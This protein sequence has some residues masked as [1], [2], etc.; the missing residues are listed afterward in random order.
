M[1]TNYF[2]GSI[3]IRQCDGY[4]ENLEFNS[5]ESKG[6]TFRYPYGDATP[7]E[8]EAIS[9]FVK[10]VTNAYNKLTVQIDGV[11]R[12]LHLEQYA[13]QQSTEVSSSEST[14]VSA[15]SQS[16]ALGGGEVSTGIKDAPFEED[17]AV[18]K[19]VQRALEEAETGSDKA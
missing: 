2:Y 9:Q 14:D 12:D 13:P 4:T 8:A 5:T 19:I 6:L 3:A 1:K 18:P 7:E 15:A 17:K 11:N 10:T 16:R